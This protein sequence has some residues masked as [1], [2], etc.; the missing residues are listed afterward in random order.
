MTWREYFAAFG[1]QHDDEL[2]GLRM[3]TCSSALV[4]A[5]AGQG[6][7]LGWSHLVQHFLESGLLQRVGTLSHRTGRRF[8]LV[9][10]ERTPLSPQAETVKDWLLDALPRD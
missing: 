3:S 4:A 5:L 2:P 9:W 7:A 8:Y 10:P 6:I 1:L